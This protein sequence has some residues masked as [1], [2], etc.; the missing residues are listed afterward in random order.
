MGVLLYMPADAVS[1]VSRCVGCP[2]H[3]NGRKKKRSLFIAISPFIFARSRCENG[4]KAA[5]ASFDFVVATEKRPDSVTVTM[6]ESP[7]TRMKIESITFLP[8][9]WV[10]KH[11]TVTPFA[12]MEAVR[13]KEPLLNASTSNNNRNRSNNSNSNS[14]NSNNNARIAA[15]AQDPEELEGTLLLPTA[16][17]VPTS[18]LNNHDSQQQHNIPMATTTV[19]TAVP[20]TYFEYDAPVIGASVE[21]AAAAT[22]TDDEYDDEKQ[23][24]L[25][26]A[27]VLP[28]YDEFSQNEQRERQLLRKGQVAGRI[29]AESE[30]Q[31]IQRLNR[32]A[33]AVNWS[34]KQ[35]IAQANRSAALQKHKEELGLV[36]TSATFREQ[37]KKTDFKK[38]TAAA[39]KEP[40]FYEGTYGKDYDTAEYET[41][42]YNT[43]EYDVQEY[44]SVYES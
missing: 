2:P 30:I 13:E 25:E 16:T 27:A 3:Q 33:Y 39:V 20:T 1:D 37:D 7:K 41:G 4:A 19:A 31:D 21:A 8:I 40:E 9:S 29:K 26:Q 22:A 36:Q 10:H 5:A 23:V 6:G 11:R 12:T 28:L 14:D 15:V 35:Q 18:S 17:A 34:V 44:K 38:K 32:D 43:A 42:E 24:I